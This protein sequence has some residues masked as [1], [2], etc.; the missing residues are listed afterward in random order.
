MA[1][2]LLAACELT[3]GPLTVFSGIRLDVD[4]VRGLVGECDFILAHTETVPRL[5][6]PLATVLEAKRGDIEAGLGQCVAQ[7]VGAR[8]FNERAG[9]P[10]R[11]LFGCVTTGDIWQFLRLEGAIVTID[12]TLLYLDNLGGI[13][14]ALQAILSPKGS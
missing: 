7:L 12:R 5:R 1:P 8:L 10:S 6:A 13:L 2:I 11:S 4:S 14:A 3:A 9:E